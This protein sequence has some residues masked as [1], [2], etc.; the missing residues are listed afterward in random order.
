MHKILGQVAL[1]GTPIAFGSNILAGLASFFAE[2]AKARNPE[3]FIRGVARGS[4]TLLKYATFGFFNAFS[5]VCSPCQLSLLPLLGLLPFQ[6]QL[7]H[8]SRLHVS[9]R[10]LQSSER[11]MVLSRPSSQ[12]V[13]SSL[14]GL[15]A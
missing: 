10:D 14:T 12:P 15:G 8:A 7:F 13:S 11:Q 6:M 1:L 3:E 5:Q 2:P 9:R 4:A